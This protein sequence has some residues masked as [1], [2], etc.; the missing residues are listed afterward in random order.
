MIRREQVG[1]VRAMEDVVTS[2][3]RPSVQVLTRARASVDE[4]LTSVLRLIVACGGLAI[5]WI[6]PTESGSRIQLAYAVLGLFAVYS[7]LSHVQVLRGARRVAVQLAPWV[8]LGWVTV[9]IAVSAGTSSIFFALYLF[10]ILGASFQGGFRSGMAMLFA[11]VLSFSIVGSL[12]APRGP[13]FELDRALIRPLHL[14]AIGYLI[15]FWGER[16]RSLRARLTLL[17]EVTTLS[18]PRF[19]IDRTLGRLLGALRAFFDADSCRLVARDENG[20]CWSRAVL[21]EAKEAGARISL[22]AQV[23]R[24]LLPFPSEA[25]FLFGHSPVFGP[26]LERAHFSEA[27]VRWVRAG[28]AEGDAGATSLDAASLLSVPFRDPAHAEA[29]ML[30]TSSRPRAFERA[31]VD[32]VRQVID[33]VAPVLQSIRVVDRLASDAAEE[34]RRRI[35]RDIHDSVIQPYIGLRLGLWA[36]RDALVGGRSS[37]AVAHVQRLAELADGEIAS[38]RRYVNGLSEATDGDAQ[39]LP[40]AVDRFCARF[41][42]ATGIQV[43]VATQLFE[44][45]NDRL[46]AE[47]FQMVAEGLS[48]VRKHS[49]ASRAHVRIAAVDGRLRID[50]ENDGAPAEARNGFSPRSLTERATALGGR[51]D[52][53]SGSGDHTVLRI[54]VPL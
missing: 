20:E 24:V 43:T 13:A 44:Q 26:R 25:G 39:L 16:Q 19:G 7:V 30:L 35:A 50:I 11:A 23:A 47:I 10:A 22:P 29:R 41:G 18:N 32:F 38:L 14:L 12:T 37:E 54:D 5:F 42:K 48:N 34:E 15:T 21:A 40:R 45:L 9:L 6:D 36:V 33:Q 4:R 27:D 2:S 53:E 31:D 3:A 1:I 51:V 28:P 49:V 8:D 17:R 46:A 52:V